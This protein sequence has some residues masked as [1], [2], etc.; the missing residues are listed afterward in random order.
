MTGVP[1][2]ERHWVQQKGPMPGGCAR[3]WFAIANR[4]AWCGIFE[5][6]THDC[7]MLVYLEKGNKKPVNERF[8]S[9]TLAQNRA[10]D[11][12]NNVPLDPRPSLPANIN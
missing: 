6:I 8:P 4:Q 2:Q 5:L 10:I 3:A 11:V 1:P 12:L 9:F 7:F